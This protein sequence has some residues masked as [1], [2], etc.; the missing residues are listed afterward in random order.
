M[1]GISAAGYQFLIAGWCRDFVGA[2][3]ADL[4]A[5]GGWD[6]KKEEQLRQSF[7]RLADAWSTYRHVLGLLRDAG[8]GEGP[9]PGQV[10]ADLEAP[11]RRFIDALDAYHAHL[12][13]VQRLLG[14]T[15]VTG[16]L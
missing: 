9:T 3:N 16:A 12:L 5:A 4:K 2:V 7:N 11:R 1:P 15:D 13:T 6:D 14:G 8:Y 10:M